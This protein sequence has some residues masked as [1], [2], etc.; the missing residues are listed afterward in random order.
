MPGLS[1]EEMLSALKIDVALAQKDIFLTAKVIDKLTEAVEKIEAMNANLCK[2]IALHELK[3][4]SSQQIHAEFDAD[5]RAVH[6]RIDGIFSEKPS[7]D[8]TQEE[9]VTRTLHTLERWKWILIGALIVLGY[10]LGHVEWTMVFK[11]IQF[12]GQ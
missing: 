6:G 4:D 11:A 8:L 2:M 12:R 9:K 10:I 1:I 5:M 3:H 7:V